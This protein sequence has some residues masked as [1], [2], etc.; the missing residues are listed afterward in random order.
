[1]TEHD[2]ARSIDETKARFKAG[3]LTFKSRVGPEP[4]AK[5]Y[6]RMAAAERR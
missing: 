4:L 2:D 1:M 3:W 5:V 6:A